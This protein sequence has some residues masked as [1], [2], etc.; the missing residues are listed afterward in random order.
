[1]TPGITRADKSIIALALVLVAALYISLWGEQSQ[2]EMVYIS[3]AGAPPLTV[4]L[5]NNKRLEIKG[6]VGTSVIEIKDRQV[7]FLD[8]PC[9]SKRCIIA[10]T[11]SKDSEIV[12]CLPNAIS[13]RIVGRDARFDA[14]NF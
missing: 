12:A 11:I 5:D 9:H 14:V 6:A 2:G 10:G 1:M 4:P 7:R 3:V 13:A 8:S